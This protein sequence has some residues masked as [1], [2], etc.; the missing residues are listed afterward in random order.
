[1]PMSGSWRC[2]PQSMVQLA[3][4]RLCTPICFAMP[5]CGRSCAP[6]GVQ[7]SAG[8]ARRVV[9]HDLRAML[10]YLLLLL[11]LMRATVG[12]REVLVTEISCCAINSRC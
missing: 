7:N 8:A 2:A 11:S 4:R 6:V 1:M 3:R 10:E 12:D 9:R 5:V